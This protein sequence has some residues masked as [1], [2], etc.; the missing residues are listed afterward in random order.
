MDNV[1]EYTNIKVIAHFCIKDGFDEVKFRAD[2][3]RA[4]VKIA[5]DHGAADVGADIEVPLLYVVLGE[6]G[7][8]EEE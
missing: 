6:C 3:C 5:R 2:M 7:D 8:D 1:A 4:L